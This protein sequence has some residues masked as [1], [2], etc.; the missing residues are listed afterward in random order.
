MHSIIQRYR[1]DILLFFIST[2]IVILWASSSG[3]AHAVSLGGDEGM[4]MMKACLL[5]KG[6]PLY[7]E[8]WSDQP[9]LFTWLIAAVLGLFDKCWVPRLISCLGLLTILFGW[10]L[11]LAKTH[12]LLAAFVFILILCAIH[13]TLLLAI[14]VMQEIPML[15]CGSL[16]LLCLLWPTP[17]TGLRFWTSVVFASAAV[18]IKL[19]GMVIVLVAIMI[20]WSDRDR[21]GTFGSNTWIRWAFYCC[22]FI[23]PILIIG[24]VGHLDMILVPHLVSVDVA[25]SIAVSEVVPT[26]KHLASHSLYIWMGVLGLIVTL[27]APRE[28]A[29]MLLFFVLEAAMFSFLRPWWS[30]YWIGIGIVIGYFAGIAVDF[31]WRKTCSCR[32][33]FQGLALIAAFAGLCYFAGHVGANMLEVRAEVLHVGAQNSPVVVKRIKSLSLSQYGIIDGDPMILVWAGKLTLPTRAIVSKKRLWSGNIS[34]EEIEY[35]WAKYK[36]NFIVSRDIETFQQ[37]PF[38]KDLLKNMNGAD[39]ASSEFKIFRTDKQSD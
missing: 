11:L 25:A 26:N 38:W 27:R 35:Q 31:A 7:R 13:P 23:G 33:Q 14:S 36:P 20:L 34:Y 15:A 17:L 2:S 16:A 24:T 5:V 37:E 39:D 1:W 3:I 9:P 21:C 12:S 4:E 22:I 8:I 10:S 28:N 18:L 29:G 32:R 19:T 30:Y 6:H